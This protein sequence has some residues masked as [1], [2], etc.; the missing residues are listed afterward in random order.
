MKYSLFMYRSAR[1]IFI[2][3]LLLVLPLFLFQP[4]SEIFGAGLGNLD[5]GADTSLQEGVQMP[6]AGLDPVEAL[7]AE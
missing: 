3:L 7:R 6:A 1:F 4:A 2:S 5:A